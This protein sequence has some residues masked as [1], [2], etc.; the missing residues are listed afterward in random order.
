MRGGLV[1]QKAPLYQA[2]DERSEGERERPQ[3][4]IVFPRSQPRRIYYPLD[5]H[6]IYNALQIEREEK[7]IYRI[8][9]PIALTASW[10]IK[11]PAL[12]HIYVLARWAFGLWWWKIL[13]FANPAAAR[14]YFASAAASLLNCQDKCRRTDE[15]STGDYSDLFDC[16]SICD[17][18]AIKHSISFTSF[19][20]AV[21]N[22]I[23]SSHEHQKSD[24]CLLKL[25]MLHEKKYL[26]IV[27][28]WYEQKAVDFYTTSILLLSL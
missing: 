19:S 21:L 12:C 7:I 9:K 26:A 14:G 13:F 16:R 18:C 11:R 6:H 25:R 28:L 1:A 4:K 5:I 24:F 10:I 15:I 20:T 23:P 3:M 8:T 2:N 27:E 17:W 22:W